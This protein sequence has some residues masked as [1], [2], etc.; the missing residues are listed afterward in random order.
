VNEDEVSWWLV[1]W[2]GANRVH[3]AL[4]DDFDTAQQ[5]HNQVSRCGPFSNVRKVPLSRIKAM[6]EQAVT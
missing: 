4:F 6:I 2:D 3:W 5:W 1:S